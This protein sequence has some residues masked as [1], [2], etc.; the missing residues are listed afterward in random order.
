MIKNILPE[1]P[2]F[3]NLNRDQIAELSTWLERKEIARGQI[4][5]KEGEPSDG[6][7]VL[8]RGEVEVIKKTKDGPLVVTELEAPTV[9]GEM[10]LLNEES[11]SADVRTRTEVVCGFLSAS[12]FAK[13]L[14]ERNLIALLIA[15]NLGRIACLRLRT[16]TL[17]LAELSEDYA[18]HALHLSSG[19]DVPKGK[20]TPG[21]QEE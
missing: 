19:V 18:R 4:V 10:G 12:L 21:V 14:E 3:E 8:A 7:Y 5:V 11:R 9:V 17:R 20:S 6:L 1:I 2:I 16:T 15:L 13:K